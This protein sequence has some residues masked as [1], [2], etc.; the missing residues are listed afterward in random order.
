MVSKN[1]VKAMGIAIDKHR[2]PYK[3]GWIEKRNDIWVIELCKVPLSIGKFYHDDIICDVLE[4]DACHLL[5]G[6]PW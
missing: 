4:M 6:R 2:K 1:L 3:V 5:L